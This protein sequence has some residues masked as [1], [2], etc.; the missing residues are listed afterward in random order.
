MVSSVE[1]AESVS[2]PDPENT[3][4]LTQTTLSLDEAG[5]IIRV[6][7][8]RFPSIQGPPAQDICYA[9]ENRQQAVKRRAA[10]CDLLLVVGSGNSS[11][12]KRLVEVGGNAGVPGYL[13]D[14]ERDIEEHWLEGVQTGRRHRGRFGAR[15]AGRT[16]GRLFTN[17]FRV[18][19]RRR[20]GS[21]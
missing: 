15:G 17:P 10:E 16:C 5:Q 3:Y 9:T 18:R 12:S 6:L 21:R 19:Q 2:V 11:N 13:I 1:E 7:E 20:S 4:Y 14:D 8:E